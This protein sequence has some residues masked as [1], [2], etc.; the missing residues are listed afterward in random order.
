MTLSGGER[1][2]IGIARALLK[3]APILVLD[4]PTASLDADNEALVMD[5]IEHLMAGRSV[6]LI[7]HRLST[8]RRADRIAVLDR[9]RLVEL[10][11]HEDLLRAGGLYR[12]LWKASDA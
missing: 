5:A 8:L 12:R 7:A 9:G 4:E 2:R 1:Q 6:L 10:G 3:N 11:T